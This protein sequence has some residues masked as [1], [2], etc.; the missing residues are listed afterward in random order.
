MKLLRIFLVLA[1]LPA[2][3]FM[4][5]MMVMR[6]RGGAAGSQIGGFI[7]LARKNVLKMG[8]S[9]RHNAG[10]LGHQ[11]KPQQPAAELAHLE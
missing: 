10:H 9:K 11:E 7:L 5:V 2:A 6:M 3:I 4:M 8:A 1:M